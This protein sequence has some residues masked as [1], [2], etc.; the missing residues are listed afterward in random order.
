MKLRA[1]LMLL[2]AC[3]LGTHARAEPALVIV[4]RH[5]ERATEPGNDPG[6]SPAGLQRARELAE[7]LSGAQVTAVL[8]TQ[9]LRAVETAAPVAKRFGVEPRVVAVRRGEAEAHVPELVAAIRRLSGVVLVVGHSNTVADIVAGLS[10][11]RPEPLCESSFAHIFLVVPQP[12]GA[13]VLQFRYGKPDPTP[14]AG[15]Q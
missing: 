11:Q 6:L 3:L 4:V 12:S 2:L 5:A 8:T 1:T 13:A 10:Q 7:Y 15:C 9:Y 14:T